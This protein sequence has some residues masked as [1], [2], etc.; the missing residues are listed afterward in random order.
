MNRTVKDPAIADRPKDALIIVNCGLGGQAKLGAKILVDCA[1][2]APQT[3]TAQLR[4]SPPTSDRAVA[5]RGAARRF[6]G[7][8]R[9]RQTGGGAAPRVADGFTNVK[10]IDGGCMAYN[11]AFPPGDCCDKKKG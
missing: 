5:S 10:T 7:P 1:P 8:R 4:L 11:K 2:T 6:A 9:P 3:A